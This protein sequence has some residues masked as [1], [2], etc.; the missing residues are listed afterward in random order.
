MLTL[1]KPF[2]N[3]KKHGCK[4]GCFSIWWRVPFAHPKSHSI[5]SRT[6]K[7]E[8]WPHLRED[9]P[10][11]PGQQQAIKRTG[12]Q[13]RINLCP[14]LDSKSCAT[15]ATSSKSQLDQSI[16]WSNQLQYHG[17]IILLHT[18]SIPKD[19]YDQGPRHPGHMGGDT[20]GCRVGCRVLGVLYYKIQNQHGIFGCDHWAVCGIAPLWSLVKGDACEGVTWADSG[21]SCHPFILWTAFKCLHILVVDP[22]YLNVFG[23]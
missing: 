15:E 20:L 10:C 6:S 21:S 3:S 14:T 2:W 22:V 4:G 13:T 23:Q 7:H 9:R 19:Q 1:T 11:L 5:L 12:C 16:H 18:T 17:D 8:A